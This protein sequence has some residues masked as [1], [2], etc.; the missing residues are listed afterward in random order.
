[1]AS[2]L[3]MLSGASAQFSNEGG[4]ITLLDKQGLKIDGVSYTKEQVARQGWTI[5]F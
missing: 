1:G 3:V 2:A 4:I 5:V